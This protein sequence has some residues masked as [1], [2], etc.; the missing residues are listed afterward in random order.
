[1]MLA[2]AVINA[3][4][5]SKT[6]ILCGGTKENHIRFISVQK[7]KMKVSKFIMFYQDQNLDNG[8]FD[9]ANCEF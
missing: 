8:S 1:M 5:N 3:I 2:T 6:L 7:K 9:C 4:K